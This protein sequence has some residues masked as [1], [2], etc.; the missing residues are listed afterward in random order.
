MTIKFNK[1]NIRF[2]RDEEGNIDVKT[3]K[4]GTNN[5]LKKATFEYEQEGRFWIS[6]AKTESKYGTMTGKQC[7]FFY[8]SGGGIV[9]ID[10]YKK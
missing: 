6:V 1:H 8:Y 2:P 3:C 10:V 9:T 5:Q 4:Y 7:P